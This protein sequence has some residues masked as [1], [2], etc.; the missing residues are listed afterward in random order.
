MQPIAKLVL[1]LDGTISDPAIGICRSLNFALQ[2]FGYA[3][4]P[5]NDVGQYIGPPLDESFRSITR[6]TSPRHVAELVAKYRERYADVGY[7]E[8]VIYPGMQ[9]TLASL[10]AAGVRLGV[11]TSKRSDFAEQIL[12]MFQLRQYF[13]FVSGGDIGV[14]KASQ[15]AALLTQ[16]AVSPTSIM[17]GDRAV[18]VAAA[19]ANGIRSAGVLW[20]HGTANELSSAT[21]DHL[22]EHPEDLM[23]LAALGTPC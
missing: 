16:S 15:L 7:S 1:D 8:N 11:C 4:V 17:V 5:E 21:P 2:H 6:T 10:A 18:D 14:T 13:Q 20:G 12:G 22:L 23:K 19:K 9:E 3:T